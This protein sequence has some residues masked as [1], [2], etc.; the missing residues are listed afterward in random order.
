[1]TEEECVA[2]SNVI[3]KR[4]MTAVS[5]RWRVA[6]HEA[7]HGLVAHHMGNKVTLI[8][9]KP[10]GGFDGAAH[11]ETYEGTTRYTMPER[12]ILVC[13]AGYIAERVMIGGNDPAKCGSDMREA[14]AGAV[15]QSIQEDSADNAR[16][17]G[18]FEGGVAIEDPRWPKQAEAERLVGEMEKEC[19][20]I[21]ESRKAEL[22]R[23]A[24]HLEKYDACDGGDVGAVCD[25]TWKERRAE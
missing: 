8:S 1:M 13:V 5:E 23:L 24:T 2:G 22:E 9:I 4:M 18:L 15:G 17:K 3:R 11:H 21:L 16:A 25:G 19:R 20:R 12:Y 14:W 7:G 6:V 10:G